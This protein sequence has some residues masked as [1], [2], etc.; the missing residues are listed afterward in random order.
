M[1]LTA[2]H[3]AAYSALQPAAFRAAAAA[4]AAVSVIL[5]TS[6]W[7]GYSSVYRTPAVPATA[8]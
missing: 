4:A 3:R 7:R 1:A 5:P 6:T 8:A 2:V